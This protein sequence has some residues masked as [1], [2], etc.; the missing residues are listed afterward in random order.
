M[1]ERSLVKNGQHNQV[2]YAST[3]VVTEIQNLKWHGV[4]VAVTH[5]G[6]T[7]ASMLLCFCVKWFHILEPHLRL[8]QT[9]TVNFQDRLDRCGMMWLAVGAGWEMMATLRSCNRD[10]KTMEC[11]SSTTSLRLPL[12]R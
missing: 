12:R 4:Q 7:S 8:N 6:L 9:P 3:A 1:H 2:L 10:W 11:S 5:R